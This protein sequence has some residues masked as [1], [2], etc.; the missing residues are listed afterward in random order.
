MGLIFWIFVAAIVTTG[1][2]KIQSR[3]N[4]GKPLPQWC[5]RI[6]FH[7]IAKA[8]L[9][10]IDEPLCDALD[11]ARQSYL[12]VKTP[13]K[14]MVKGIKGLEKGHW[15]IKKMMVKGIKGWEKGH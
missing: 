10:K 13:K 1:T 9:M 12:R 15:I 3:G 11:A 5:K 8:L 4:V 6:F 7:Y 2:L 14:M